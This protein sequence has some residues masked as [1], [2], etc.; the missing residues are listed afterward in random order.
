M[1][2]FK[3]LSQLFMVL[4]LHLQWK[5]NLKLDDQVTVLGLLAPNFLVGVMV[6]SM[7]LLR[8]PVVSEELLRV[9]PDDATDLHLQL[10]P[11]QMVDVDVAASEGVNQWDL[12]LAEQ[13]V[14]HAT[15]ELVLQLVNTDN[16]VPRKNVQPMI[17]LLLEHDLIV[18]H[19][20]RLNEQGQDLLLFNQLQP[21]AMVTNLCQDLACPLTVLTH[22]FEILMVLSILNDQSPILTLFTSQ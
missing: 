11:V 18:M 20:P 5:L 14:A 6:M 7:R 3:D 2:G 10:R 16:N 9:W 22:H 17:T 15:E 8:H 13:I 19:G 1:I 4:H 12:N 21:F